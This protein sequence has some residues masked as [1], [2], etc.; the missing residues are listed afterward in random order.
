MR[1]STGLLFLAWLALPGMSA[2]QADRVTGFSFLKLDPSARSSALAGSFMAI[3]DGDVNGLYYNPA[4]LRPDMSGAV[5]FSYLNHVSDI[6][7]AFVTYSRHF[8]G[9]ASF[10]AGL[11]FLSWGSFERA[12]ELGEREGTFSAGDL[13]LT[14]GAAREYSDRI[15][16]GASV[17]MVYS[18]IESYR[19]SALAADLGATYLLPESQFSASVSV[20]NIGFTV[21]SFGESR[22]DLPFD[23]R[24]GVAKR[25]RYLPLLV[26]VTAYDL[27]NIGDAP[28]GASGFGTV[29]QYLNFGGELRFSPAFQVRLGYSHRKHEA[30][31]QKSRLD[32]AGLG[33]GVG[34]VVRKIKV[35]YAYGSWS[36]L[37]SLNQLTIGTTL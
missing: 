7:A 36:S 26:T 1:I 9:V 22:D 33:I 31:K 32:L 3:Y 30:L 25:L 34:I 20:N 35:D 2:A 12:N 21:D 5:S 8:D 18:S 28:Q 6:N 4:L 24:V 14:V 10:G 15:R 37:G 16:Y 29:F 23:V 17:H 11:R 19:A 13:A 27:Q